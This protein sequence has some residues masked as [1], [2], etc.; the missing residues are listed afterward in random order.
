M[1]ASMGVMPELETAVQRSAKPAETSFTDRQESLPQL[2]EDQPQ[3]ED[4]MEQQNYG[5]AL[6]PP[7]LTD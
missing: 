2:T 7:H 1:L 4:E 5:G 6:L 3:A